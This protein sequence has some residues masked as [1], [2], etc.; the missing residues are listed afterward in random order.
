MA[1]SGNTQQSLRRA[2]GAL[3]DSTKVGLA[4]VNSENKEL[5]VALVKATN[6][7][8]ILAKE[9]HIM[10][11]F[12]ALSASSPR[13]DVTYCINGLTKR[14]AK[15]HNWTVALK[16]LIVI[17]RALREVDH[18]FREELIN[19]SKGKR[20]ML[21]LSHFRD[22]SS[23]HAWDYSAWVRAYALYLEEH[24]ECFCVLKYDIRKNPSRT[25]ELD[26]PDVLEQLPAMQQLLLRLLACKPQGMAVHNSLIHYALSIVAGESVKLYV[27]ITDGVL[28]VVDK[29]DFILSHYFEMERHD[30]IRALEIYK[31]AVSQGE[32]LSEF[33]EMCRSVDFGRQQKFIKIKMPPASFLTAMEDYVA[34]APHVLAF[35]WIQI[36][37]DEDGTPREVSTPHA[38]L[39][40]DYKHV[41]VK[42]KSNVCLRSSDP[43]KSNQS[44][45]TTATLFFT[46]LLGLD[47]L[48]QE[49]SEMDDKNSPA[50][51]SV[52][53]DD[54]LNCETS[55]NST[56]QTTGWELA[57]V[58]AP[59]SDGVAAGGLDK[60]TL[61]SLYDGAMATGMNQKSACQIGQMAPNP[62]DSLDNNQD[63]FYAPSDTVPAT[64]TQTV[65]IS[66]E[67]TFLM[68]Q[69]QKQQQQQLPVIDFDTNST[70]P[71]GNPFVDD[72]N[73][74]NSFGG[75]NNVSF[76]HPQEF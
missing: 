1:A 33:F 45:T 23:P 37:E 16:T 60:L 6:H 31:K 9:K 25:K 5:D 3:K 38:T 58:T 51:T 26:I 70:N 48:T 30:A 52:T 27:A 17:H 19:F 46:D 22:D 34:E 57:L 36:S 4:K 64:N 10:T 41:D 56:F 75:D 54:L 35:E 21:N 14:L 8:E 44:E 73:V 12:S 76:H 72:N 50:F 66:E 20:L 42:E 40:I 67:Q 15:T 43:T 68:M 49:A 62:F 7:D 71:F 29:N 69:Q 39:L 55:I 47:E 2:I 59:S 24:L 13:A 74:P 53:S 32:K 63:P 18:T 65:A 28:N 11:I 61:E